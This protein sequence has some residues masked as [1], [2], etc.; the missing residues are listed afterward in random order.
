V[1]VPWF[2]CDKSLTWRCLNSNPGQ[3]HFIFLLSLLCLE[4]HVCLSRGMQVAGAA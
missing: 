4:N 2:D 1:G 3:F